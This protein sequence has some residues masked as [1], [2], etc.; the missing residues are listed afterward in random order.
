MSDSILLDDDVSPPTPVAVSHPEPAVSTRGIVFLCLA[1]ALVVLA[2]PQVVEYAGD[3]LGQGSE[4]TMALQLTVFVVAFVVIGF[5]GVVPMLWLRRPVT[6]CL[7][8]VATQTI[9]WTLFVL[10][11][12]VAAD[13]PNFG[14]RTSFRENMVGGTSLFLVGAVGGFIPLGLLI[15]LRRWSLMSGPQR[16]PRRA[17]GIVDMLALITAG[18]AMFAFQRQWGLFSQES[19]ND[20]FL[21]TILFIYALIGST[22]TSSLLVAMRILLGP[23][24]D[25]FNVRTRCGI[26]GTL[27][28]AFGIWGFIMQVDGPPNPQRS[29]VL[30]FFAYSILTWSAAA[31]TSAAICATVGKCGLRLSSSQIEKSGR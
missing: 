7:V 22:L 21:L 2:T 1:A 11:L 9:L 28:L 3:A 6:R 15:W 8:A 29:S 27:V 17:V 5:A 31:A 19:A 4:F 12:T 18:A 26:A 14:E 16:E 30:Q 23:T 20:S 10:G 13:T 24:N 25:R